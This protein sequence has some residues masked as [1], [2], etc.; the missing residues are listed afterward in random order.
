MKILS[1]AIAWVFPEYQFEWIVPEFE[2]NLSKELDFLQEAS[3]AE[4]TGR[5]FS[6]KEVVKVPEIHWEL[7]TKRVLTMQFMYGWKVDDVQ[8][9]VKAG[10]DPKKVAEVLAEV[11]AAMIFCH[12]FVHGDPHP[13]NILVSG[14]GNKFASNRS[15]F[16]IVLLDHGLYRELDEQFRSEFCH[17]WKALILL[18]PVKLREAGERLGAGRYYRYLPVI[19]TGRS[20]SSKS[21]LGQGMSPEEKMYLKDELRNFSVGDISQ[22]MEGL[23]RDFLTILRTDGLLRSIIAKLGAESRVRLL[24]YAKYA[25][26]GAALRHDD[27]PDRPAQNWKVA[28]KAS[29]E[30]GQLRIRLETLE[31]AHKLESCYR[32]LVNWLRAFGSGIQGLFSLGLSIVYGLLP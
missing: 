15:D 1:K 31:I 14:S 32:A 28:L 20:L 7:C 30:Y 6:K 4:K 24:I 11:F 18:D 16:A 12:G 2:K 10:I 27:A 25:V 26:L 23:P 3:N 29:L 17:L 13:G 22:F 19:F 21:G 8:S 5:N 9:L